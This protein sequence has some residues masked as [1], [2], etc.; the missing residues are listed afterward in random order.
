MTLFF[1][2]FFIIALKESFWD[3]ILKIRKQLV[4]L[5]VFTFSALLII[6]LFFED[7]FV[8]HFTEALF[9]VANFW[10]WILVIFAYGFLHLNK[11][12]R[13]LQYCNTA[14]YPFYILH[15]T[16]TIIIGY[17][18]M[19]KDWS[20]AIKFP[21]MIIGTFFTAWVIYEFLIRR[22]F[23]MRPFLGLKKKVIF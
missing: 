13:L 1:Y 9:K 6:W 14:V 22:L 19:D 21:I 2:G 5:G 18:I 10:T 17:W 7:G 4:V 16:I 23:F 3:A 12:S 20:L 15:Q 8:I 11:P